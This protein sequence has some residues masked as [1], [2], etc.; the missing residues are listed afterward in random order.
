[1]IRHLFQLVWNRKRANG[2]IFTE[3]LVSFLVLSVVVTAVF[4]FTNN[5][6]KP[7]CF[8]FENVWQLSIRASSH[9]EYM[10]SPEESK[11]QVWDRVQHIHRLLKQSPEIDSV[12][13][14]E[15]QPYSDNTSSWSFDVGDREM[16]VLWGDVSIE[17]RDVLDLNVVAGRW[18]EPGDALLEA[19]KAIVVSQKTAAAL[20]PNEDAVG[21]SWPY[22]T[23]DG[24]RRDR[25]EEETDYRVVGII[26]DWRRDGELSPTP[27]VAFALEGLTLQDGAGA[28]LNLQNRPPDVMLLKLRAGTTPAFEEQLVERVRRVAPDWTFEVTAL[29]QTRSRVLRAKLLPVLVGGTIAFFLIIMVA[30][31]LVGV[32]WLNVTR[33]TH[34]MG[35]RRALGATANGVRAQVLGE[36]LALSTLAMGVGVVFALQAPLLGLTDNVSARVLTLGLVN[37]VVLLYLLVVLCG[38]YPS[39]LAT[40]IHPARA[41]QYE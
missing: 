23:E 25:T 36:I 38:L 35:V 27:L 34:E 12:A 5:Y 33:R 28:S 37:S 41:L 2:L 7:L 26:Q 24:R 40:R 10:R 21:L 16:L 3:I 39:W 30:L 18:F 19:W 22:T 29:D 32:L 8:D 20:W 14:F 17:A 9:F 1:M 13:F 11:R 15:N 31:G 4:Y 6:R